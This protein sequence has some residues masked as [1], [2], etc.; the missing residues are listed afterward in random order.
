MNIQTTARI[1]IVDDEPY[2]GELLR[3]YLASEGF[4]CVS[5]TSGKDALTLLDKEEFDLVVSD[6][7][8]PGMSGIELLEAAKKLH[9]DVAVIMVTGVDDRKTAVNALHLGA[10][11]YVIKPFDR[12][13]IIISA[14]GALERRRLELLSQRYEEALEAKVIERTLQTKQRE[15]EI[16]IRLMSATGCRDNETGAHVRR[17]GLYSATMAAALG[18]RGQ[19]VADIR[20]AAAMHDVGKIAIPDYILRKKGRLSKTEFDL[21]KEHTRTGAGIL[22]GSDVPLLQMAEEIALCHHERWDGSGYPSGLAGDEIPESAR[23]V[24]V[25]DV[26]DALVNTRIYKPAI[27]EEQ[28]L[29][30]MLAESGKHFDPRILEVFFSVLP[31]IRRIREQVKED[32]S[33]QEGHFAGCAVK[34][35]LGDFI[36]E[37]PKAGLSF[38]AALA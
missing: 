33:D 32:D 37:P 6:I 15:E 21:M 4:I 9:P 30:M 7:M 3:R 26:Y 24:A 18:W 1:L 10:Y 25:A 19:A 23:I 28:S 31:E 16:I 17:I 20:L 34:G 35:L 11:G 29:D 36:S 27:S 2:V 14:A 12:N 13:E 5:V 22:S 38:S 8:M